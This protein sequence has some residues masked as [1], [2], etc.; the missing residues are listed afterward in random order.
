MF[1]SRTKNLTLA[2]GK[3]IYG[4]KFQATGAPQKFFSTGFAD[5][6]RAPSKGPK[7]F[8]FE[9]LIMGS[10]SLTT[11]TG[12]V[13]SI[14][15]LFTGFKKFNRQKKEFDNFVINDEKLNTKK[16]SKFFKANFVQYLKA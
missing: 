4:Q 10:S 6:D 3:P 15:Y 2:L 12:A 7:K 11:G 13:D 8:V 1:L 5:I 9:D 14:P 16:L